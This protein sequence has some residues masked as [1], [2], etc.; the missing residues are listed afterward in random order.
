MID[1][2]L[3]ETESRVEV[4]TNAML[5]LPIRG[6]ELEFAARQIDLALNQA[7]YLR[8]SFSQKEEVGVKRTASGETVYG[9]PVLGWMT[10]VDVPG[11]GLTRRT[12]YHWSTPGKHEE[13]VR[14]VDARYLQPTVPNAGESDGWHEVH[15][16]A[17]PTLREGYTA[18]AVVRPGVWLVKGQSN[19]AAALVQP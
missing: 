6:K 1:E 12:D 9:V 19:I 10:E 17:Q 14:L 5:H 15:Q 16:E 18:I 8:A 13:V 7:R 4:I 11:V 2:T 3:S